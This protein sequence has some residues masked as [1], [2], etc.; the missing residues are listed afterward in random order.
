MRVLL[1]TWIV[2]AT[3]LV[4]FMPP[5]REKLPPRRGEAAQW[6]SKGAFEQSVLASSDVD[7]HVDISRL[8]V[9]LLALNFLPAVALWQ[10]D[11]FV[12][13]YGLH[14]REIR[15]LSLALLTLL[16]V[17]VLLGV[18]LAIYEQARRAS[19]DGAS[20][21]HSTTSPRASTGSEPAFD[22][23]SPKAVPEGSKPPAAAP[24]LLTS[25][26]TL[27]PLRLRFAAQCP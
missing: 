25:R 1:W 10:Y 4:F 8:I 15:S 13:G 9:T 21:G 14:Q 6:M 18:G 5:I 16:A 17:I 12:I 2:G 11:G 20:V 19:S 27:T 7:T 24:K 3:A 26:N 23:G 22:W